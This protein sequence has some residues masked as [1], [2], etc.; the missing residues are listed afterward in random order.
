MSFSLQPFR[1]RRTITDSPPSLPSFSF[2]SSANTRPSKPYL[3]GL[4]EV[5]RFINA[6]LAENPASYI[7][8]T[9]EFDCN[10]ELVRYGL[11]EHLLSVAI[12]TLGAEAFSTVLPFKDENTLGAGR[13]GQPSA[14][15]ESTF[16]SRRD[17]FLPS[18]HKLVA[19]PLI[20][21]TPQA[22]SSLVS[23]VGRSRQQTTTR[24]LDSLSSVSS[25]SSSTWESLASS[26]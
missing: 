5:T 17:S 11:V 14:A 8:P 22:S 21:S 7:P 2:L 9:L 6:I 1:T 23:S 16:L 12:S 13:N 3:L 10:L 25:R 18:K 26:G 15:C 19:D 4:L 20:F 24:P